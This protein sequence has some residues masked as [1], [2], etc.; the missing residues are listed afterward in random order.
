MTRA[1]YP[2]LGSHHCEHPAPYRGG[3]PWGCGRDE[4]YSSR[5]TIDQRRSVDATSVAHDVPS[6]GGVVSVF[7]PDGTAFRAERR[8]RRGCF[9]VCACTRRTR[10]VF[11]DRGG[12]SCRVCA[13]LRY[14]SQTLS[15][16]LR[17]LA[18][19]FRGH[20][21]ERTLANSQERILAARGHT[22]GVGVLDPDGA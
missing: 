12:W 17:R 19:R 4:P 5:A 22:L 21:A 7:W 1:T 16:R 8:P 3:R 6:S 14:P 2:P 20:F 10:R 13:G 18:G 9:F 11:E 15:S